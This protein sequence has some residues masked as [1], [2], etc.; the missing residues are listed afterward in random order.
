MKGLPR[1]A[2]NFTE[3]YHMREVNQWKNTKKQYLL[4]CRFLRPTP[5]L[6]HLLGQVRKSVW[7]GPRPVRT[8]WISN[9]FFEKH[10][11]IELFSAM[12]LHSSLNTWLALHS[13]SQIILYA[14]IS[15]SFKAGEHSSSVRFSVEKGLYQLKFV[16]LYLF[17]AFNSCWDFKYGQLDPYSRCYASQIVDIFPLC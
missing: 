11:S 12:M 10:W 9:P 1:W 17:H 13:I 6:L 4:K 5:D 8:T 15:L 14:S 7:G 3:L 2:S 16:L